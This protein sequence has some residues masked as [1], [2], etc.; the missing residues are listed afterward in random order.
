MNPWP[1]RGVIAGAAGTAA[2][3]LAYRAEHAMRPE[4][5]GPLDYDD[6]LVPGQIVASVLHLPSVTQRGEQG[7]GHAAPV[8]LRLGV[9]HDA[10]V[11]ST[12]SR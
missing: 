4:V 2:M 3:T 9:R 10:W 6:S 1:I 8:G 12:A 7:V 5:R 11:P